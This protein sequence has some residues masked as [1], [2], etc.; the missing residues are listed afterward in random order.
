[1]GYHVSL[2]RE[3]NGKIEPIGR[4]EIIGIISSCP[5]FSYEDRENYLNLKKISAYGGAVYFIYQDGE[6]YVKN[7]TEIQLEEFILLAQKLGGRI[8]GENFETYRT[9]SETYIHEN[10]VQEAADHVRQINSSKSNR[11]R[12]SFLWKAGFILAC[13]I[14]G[15]LIGTVKNS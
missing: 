15:G 8:R 3:N 11:K 13:A 4:E 10:D 1:M 12:R 14:L 2:I 7:P 5:D 9:G 6:L